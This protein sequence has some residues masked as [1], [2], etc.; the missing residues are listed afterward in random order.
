M[1]DMEKKRAYDR[2]RMA[3]L[4]QSKETW[5]Q[6]RGRA[7]YDWYRYSRYTYPV[8]LNQRIARD[9]ELFAEMNGSG[10]HRAEQTERGIE[11]AKCKGREEARDAWQ[12]ACE[13]RAFEERYGPCEFGPPRKVVTTSGMVGSV[14]SCVNPEHEGKH[15]QQ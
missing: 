8:R 6:Q 15:R 12:L 7:D 10:N 13:R 11:R 1:R 14:R 9:S 4:Y 3:R 2:E 5:W